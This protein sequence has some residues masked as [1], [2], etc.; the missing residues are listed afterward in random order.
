MVKLL[1]SVKEFFNRVNVQV[2]VFALVFIVAST[3]VPLWVAINSMHSLNNYSVERLGN[4]VGGQ[5][6]K[7]IEELGD[8]AYMIR[9]IRMDAEASLSYVRLMEELREIKDRFGAVR[10]FIVTKADDGEYEYLIEGK[11]AGDSYAS[12]SGQRLDEEL[13]ESVK[14]VY[15]GT[16]V[17]DTGRHKVGDKNCRVY[18]F[19]IKTADNTVVAAA[20]MYFQWDEF[21]SSISLI[22]WFALAYII[23]AAIVVSKLSSKVFR[24]IS[25]PSY[26]DIANTDRLTDLKNKNSFDMDMHNIE[27]GGKLEKYGVVMIDLNGLKRVNDTFGHQMGDRFIQNSARILKTSVSGKD[28]VIY[29][30]GGD[31]FAIICKNTSHM[32]LESL[33]ESIDEH[34]KRENK[35]G[36]MKLSMS[37]GYALYDRSR[38]KNFSQTLQRAD[39]TMYETKRQYY[40]GK[41]MR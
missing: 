24:R 11:I 40:A 5:L 17:L 19:P 16:G 22:K 21:Y 39:L 34:V 27:N 7:D 8:V 38:D 37:M 14:G 20:C 1:R 6:Q 3:M 2:A 13:E 15:A 35:N 23:I 33:I 12:A 31:E 9:D 18:T 25:N 29:R 32:E 41:E 36:G 10:L 30:I 28:Q 26:R 4:S